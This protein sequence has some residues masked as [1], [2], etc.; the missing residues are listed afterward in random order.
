MG[1]AG[2]RWL[3]PFT[4]HRYF[5][6]WHPIPVSPIGLGLLSSYGARVAAHELLL[7]A[8]VF[9]YAMWPRRQPAR[10]VALPGAGRRPG[11]PSLGLD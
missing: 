3:W 2:L 11:P 9:A 7:F 8:P 10:H 5:A 6:P 4:D 1:G